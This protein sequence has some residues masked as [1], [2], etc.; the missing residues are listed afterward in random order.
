MLEKGATNCP[1]EGHTKEHRLQIGKEK[2]T[3]TRGGRGNFHVK[4]KEEKGEENLGDMMKRE[5][6]VEGGVK[7]RTQWKFTWRESG[8]WRG[9]ERGKMERDEGGCWL[10]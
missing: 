10:G 3:R 6:V 7:E 9:M 1:K 2:D 8:S 4:Q 5:G